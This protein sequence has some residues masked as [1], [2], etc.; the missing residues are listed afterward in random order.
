MAATDQFEFFEGRKTQKPKV[1]NYSNL[2]I[3]FP[4]KWRCACDFFKVFTEIQMAAMH[5]LHNILWEQKLKN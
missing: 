3:T 2:T 4:T 5:L 1:E